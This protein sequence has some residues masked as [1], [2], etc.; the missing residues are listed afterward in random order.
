[1]LLSFSFSPSFLFTY[2][3]I[4]LPKSSNFDLSIHNKFWRVKNIFNAKHYI[5]FSSLDFLRIPKFATKWNVITGSKCLL[6]TNV[7]ILVTVYKELSFWLRH[8]CRKKKEYCAITVFS[9]SFLF[10]SSSSSWCAASTD[11]PDLLS[12]LL[13]I[14]HCRW[15]DFR[16]ISRI[17][18][19]LLYVCSSWPSCFCSAICG[20]P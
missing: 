13:P 9:C 14:I 1:M 6:S 11:I 15:Q 3:I 12:L 4:L 10:S 16:T 2:T 8:S 7:L 18:T 5:F 19:E 20:G 17:L